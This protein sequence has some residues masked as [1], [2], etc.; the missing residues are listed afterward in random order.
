MEGLH[1][2][3][4]G[5]GSVHCQTKRQRRHHFDFVRFLGVKDEKD[6]RDNLIILGLIKRRFLLISLSFIKQWELKE[7]RLV[8]TRTLVHIRIKDRL[9]LWRSQGKEHFSGRH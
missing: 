7:G 1:E 4:Q 9:L 8:D 3:G 5:M 2:V 6:W